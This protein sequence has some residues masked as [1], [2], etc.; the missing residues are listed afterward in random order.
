MYV[1]KCTYTYMYVR[2]CTYMPTFLPK[3]GHGGRKIPDSATPE[4]QPS[5]TFKFFFLDT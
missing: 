2:Q 5:I 4:F 3:H 1:C